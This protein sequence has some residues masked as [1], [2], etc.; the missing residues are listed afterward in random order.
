MKTI[1]SYNINGIRA[2]IRQGFLEWLATHHFDVVC[3]QEVKAQ[4]EDVQAAMLE[5]ASLGYQVY[6]S[7]AEKKGYSGVATLTKVK[8]TRVMVGC[9]IPDYDNEGRILRTDFE[10]WSLLN[11]Y[12]PSGTS[13]QLRQDFKMQFLGDFAQWIDTVRQ[14]QPN[15]VV[16]GDFNIAHQEIDLHDPKRNQKSTGFLPEERD[17]VSNWLASG[18]TDAFRYKHPT[19]VAYSWWTYRAGARA[20]NKG[21][22]L[23]YHF[24]SNP[25]RTQ[26]VDAFHLPDAV[27]ADHCPVVLQLSV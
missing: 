5:I 6:W 25:L 3:L 20:Q 15:L 11:C 18:F 14:E 21:W 23:D 24:V 22:R 2:A 19:A 26:I 13:G 16:V 17:W 12:I 7:A 1:V 4:Q 10:D 9:G 8:P 27:H